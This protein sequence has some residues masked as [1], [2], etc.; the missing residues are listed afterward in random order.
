MAYPGHGLPRTSQ[1]HRQL[2]KAI[3]EWRCCFRCLLPPR[4]Q[5]S[6]LQPAPPSGCLTSA[7]PPVSPPPPFPQAFNMFRSKTGQK[8]RFAVDLQKRVPHGAGLGGGSANAATALWAANELCGRPASN[9]QLLAWSGEIGSDI[10][11][12]FSNGAAY[13]TG[14]CAAG[15]GRGRGRGGARACCAEDRTR[16]VGQACAARGARP[17]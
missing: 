15:G 10:S 13:C 6:T 7:A 9:E 8:Q 14:R 4:L 11:V 12:F 2:G 5:P 1:Q 3:K 17:R 16:R